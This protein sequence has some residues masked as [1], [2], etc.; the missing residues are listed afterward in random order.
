M[1]RPVN[2]LD[3]ERELGGFVVVYAQLF[4]QMQAG[5]VAV[6]GL[7][8]TSPAPSEEVL[9]AM[10]GQVKTMRNM[11][12]M[13][14]A[15]CTAAIDLSDDEKAIRDAIRREVEGLAA[16]RNR[17]MH[18]LWAVDSP[19]SENILR[20]QSSVTKEG[21]VQ[22]S[23]PYTPEQVHLDRERL[24]D[25]VAYVY[26]FTSGCI[27]G[28]RGAQSIGDLLRL[29]ENGAVQFGIDAPPRPKEL[30]QHP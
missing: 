24:E 12:D 27:N 14:F 6:A 23:I 2:L 8:P 29:D 5:L 15:T 18:D 7:G 11:S 25:A 17:Y 21:F 20:W 10:V 1:A 4:H 9:W 30:R 16:K 22:K 3:F 13:F 28:S 26:R 19:N